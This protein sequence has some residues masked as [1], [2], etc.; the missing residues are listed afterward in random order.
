MY[1]RHLAIKSYRRIWRVSSEWVVGKP[2]LQLHHGKRE[3][4]NHQHAAQVIEVTAWPCKTVCLDVRSKTARR[5]FRYKP[6]PF[7]R[8]RT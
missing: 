8:S 2:A 7:K 3:P 5:K 4:D 1:T 6:K